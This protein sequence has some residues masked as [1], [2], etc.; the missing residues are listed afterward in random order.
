[1]KLSVLCL[2]LYLG[3]LSALLGCPF[4]LTIY[5]IRFSFVQKEMQTPKRDI[6]GLT[7]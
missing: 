4:R 1:M 2:Y 7:I 6:Q 3:V 5:E